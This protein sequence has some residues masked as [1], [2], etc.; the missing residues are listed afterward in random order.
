MSSV[1]GAFEQVPYVLQTRV[2]N[3]WNRHLRDDHLDFSTRCVITISS[4]VVAADQKWQHRKRS[5][6]NRKPII[7][8]A[9]IGD[10]S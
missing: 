1:D 7:E 3:F 4:T 10:I 2:I 9:D 5:R 8:Y 6:L